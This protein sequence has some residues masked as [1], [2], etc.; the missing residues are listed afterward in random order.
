MQK[1][2]EQ[3]AAT[4]IA[5]DWINSD[6]AWYDY[7]RDLANSGKDN[8]TAEEELKGFIDEQNPLV[9][10]ADMFA[11]LIN[12]MLCRIDYIGIIENFREN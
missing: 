3:T 11:D 12:A 10:C 7:V 1:S 4:K 2:T 8:A 9:D 5:R 6:P